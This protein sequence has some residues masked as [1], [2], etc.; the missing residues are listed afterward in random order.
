MLMGRSQNPNH[1]NHAQR[2]RIEVSCS[3]KLHARQL[4]ELEQLGLSDV[5]NDT[6]LCRNYVIKGL[7]RFLFMC[8][9]QGIPLG[10][11]LIDLSVRGTRFDDGTVC[12]KRAADL[13]VMLQ[14][15]GN[16]DGFTTES[17][18]QKKTV[19]PSQVDSRK[20]INGESKNEGEPCQ[21]K[22]GSDGSEEVDWSDFAGVVGGT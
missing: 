13:W 15:C 11:G 14:E 12:R 20:E 1:P 19:E 4:Q 3:T 9:H 17:M 2:V 21:P 5:W 8:V 22:G 16:T 10:Q 6:Y 18:Q 7:Q